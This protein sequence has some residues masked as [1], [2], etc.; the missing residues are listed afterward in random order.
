MSDSTLRFRPR[1]LPYTQ[2]AN[3]ALRDKRM[4]LAV[5]GFFALMLSLPAD[6]EHSIAYFAKIGGISKDTVYKYFGILEGLGYLIRE[7]KHGE[8]GQ[9]AAND[10]ELNDTP[11]DVSPCRTLPDTV[12]PCT[13]EPCTE[14]SDTKEIT[15]GK[16]N[17]LE[18]PRGGPRAPEPAK[19]K[20]ERFEAFWAYYRR[21][22]NQANRSAAR[23]AWDKLKPEDALISEIAV[24]LTRR[25]RTDEEWR[26]G[27]G[28]P[29]ASTYLNGQMWLDVGPAPAPG[30][31]GARDAPQREEWG[32]ET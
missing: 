30:S 24:A 29:H 14:K 9:F 21:N 18:P 31:T 28:R 17:P 32:W 8:H 25:L 15:P 22:V 2:I 16:N 12:E 5:R 1:K 10:Y 4:S 23:K 20:P 3:V 6:K 26:R 27:I 7:Q 11:P 13:V 19:W